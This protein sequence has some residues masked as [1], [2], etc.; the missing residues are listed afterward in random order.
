MA[1][2]PSASTAVGRDVTVV[3]GWF[4]LLGVLS[5]VLWWLLVSPAEFTKLPNGGSMGEVDLGKQFNADG[6]YVVIAAVFG[7]VSGVALTWWRSRDPLLTSLLLIIGSATA[8]ALMALTGHLLGPGATRPA[9]AAAK[10]GARVPERLEVDT[11]VVYLCWP[12]AVFL[13]ALVVLLGKDVD[14]AD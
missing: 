9:L 2:H 8:A 1:R 7:L 4:V 11:F 12:I 5:G 3:I 13:G 14:T 6:W 10:V